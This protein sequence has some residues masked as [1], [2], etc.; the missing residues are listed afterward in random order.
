MLHASQSF[1]NHSLKITLKLLSLN[2]CIVS[3]GTSLVS[4]V[5]MLTGLL[6]KKPS[7]D[8]LALYRYF[9]RAAVKMS[10]DFLTP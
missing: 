4:K 6:L 9:L 10:T 2:I 5:L 8:F 3:I 7:L 1:P